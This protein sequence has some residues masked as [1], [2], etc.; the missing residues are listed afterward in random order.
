MLPISYLCDMNKVKFNLKD[1]N[2]DE[3]LIFLI[4]RYDAKRLKMST[5]IKV[6]VKHW[7]DSKQSIREISGYYDYPG[8]NAEL[9]RYVQSVQK[10]HTYFKNRGESPSILQMK[11]K[12]LE[13]KHNRTAIIAE[14]PKTVVSFIKDHIATSEAVGKK[15]GTLQGFE[16]L[17]KVIEKMPNGKSLEF[18]DLTEARLNAM[19]KHM[20]DKFDYRT[21]QIDKIQRKLVT[22]V[23]L[24]KENPIYDISPAFLKRNKSWRVKLTSQD[25]SGEGMA[26]TPD[27]LRRIEEI[28]LIDR[29]DRVRDRFLVGINVG[30]RYSTFSKLNIDNIIDFNGEKYW[31]F[32]QPK[33]RTRLKLKVNDKCLEI[34]EKYEGYPPSISLSNFNKYL[35]EVCELAQ[36]NDTYII[37]KSNPIHGIVDEQRLPKYKLASSHDCRRTLATILHNQGKPLMNIKAITGHKRIKDLERYLKIDQSAPISEVVNLY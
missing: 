20:V 21:S 27:E 1:R 29:L 37:R 19:V 33:T 36:I 9:K 31:D 10:A 24:A 4:Y 13:F 17:Q 35:K 3:S 25:S 8:N 15:R 2:A 18:K 16:Q 34:L 14:K 6:K 12:I 11:E 26:F 32:V 22:I 7:N 30:Q 5:G 23:N 28:E